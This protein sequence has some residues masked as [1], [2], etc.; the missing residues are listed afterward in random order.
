MVHVYSRGIGKGEV[1][2]FVGGRDCFGRRSIWLSVHVRMS[3]IPW[4]TPRVGWL[5]F[6]DTAVAMDRGGQWLI[7]RMVVTGGRGVRIVLSDGSE[8]SG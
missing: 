6:Q 1:V 4:Y 7:T 2:S 8:W 5:L 3:A